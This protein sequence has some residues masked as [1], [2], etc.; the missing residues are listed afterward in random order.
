[1]G[2]LEAERMK[3]WTLFAWL[4]VVLVSGCESCFNHGCVDNGP[5]AGRNEKGTGVA[6]TAA[7]PDANGIAVGAPCRIDLIRAPGKGEAYE[8]T[9]V[10]VEK[11]EVVLSNVIYEGPMK[12]P[13]SPTIT[14]V[15]WINGRWFGSDTAV[16][17]K[18]MPDKEVRVAKSEISSIKIL[19][20]DPVADFYQR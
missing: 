13:R 16:D 12:R 2:S 15:P 17:W 6:Q 4:I 20:H 5:G 11:N 7:K 14:D 18:R 3:A 9:V 8:G 10:R 1:M 19:D